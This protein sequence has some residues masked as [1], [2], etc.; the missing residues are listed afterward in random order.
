MN[1]ESKDIYNKFAPYY[2]EYSQKKYK[3]LDA[4]DDLIIKNSQNGGRILDIGC[5]DGTRSINIFQ[6]IKGNELWMIDNS[7]EMI[8]L[9]KKNSKEKIVVINED[10]SKKEIYPNLLE[11]KFTTILCL[12][13]VLGHIDNHQKMIQSLINIKKLLTKDGTFFID[14]SNR[15]NIFHYGI[16]SVTKNI[17]NDRFYY[18]ENNGIFNYKIK[19]ANKEIDSSCYFFNPS[20]FPRMCNFANLKITKTH[21]INY[22]NGKFSHKLGGHFFYI[23]KNNSE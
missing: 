7:R 1:L 18:H 23:V 22:K 6:K 15:Y 9:A 19:V 13:N 17:I 14:I 4:I 5:G 12:W 10:I 16:K 2:K 11:K 8:N 21:Y 20:E 3:Y